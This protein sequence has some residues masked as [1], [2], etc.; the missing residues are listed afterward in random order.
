[1]HRSKTPS[2]PGSGYQT[3]PSWNEIQRMTDEMLANVPDF[4]IFNEHG[5]I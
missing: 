3:V 1:M 5:K 2:K 4:T